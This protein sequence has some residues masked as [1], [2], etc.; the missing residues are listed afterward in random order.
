M[1]LT[2]DDIHA[3]QRRLAGQIVQ[4]PYSYSQTLSRI[5]GC[6]L[7]L[8][9]E[10]LQFTASFKERGA[11]N[12][13][14]SLSAEEKQRGVITVSAGNHAQ[15]VAYHA[16]KLGIRA[17][18]VMPVDTP[19]VKVENTKR[20]GAEVVQIGESFGEARVAM[21]K[22]AQRDQMVVVHP[23]DDPWVI[24]GQG[25]LGFEMMAQIPEID[26]LVVPI[27]GGGLISGI[28]L[29]VH[30]LSPSVE[31]VGV[32]AAHFPAMHDLYYQSKVPHGTV[33]TPNPERPHAPTIAD[34]IAVDQPGQLTAPIVLEHV[35]RIDLVSEAQLEQAIIYL[36]EI[37]KTV[38]EGA[39]AAGL[40]AVMARPDLFKGRRVGLV[41]CGGNIDSLTLSDIIQRS[42]VR[43][44][45]LARLSVSAR[46][47]PGSLARVATLVGQQGANIEEVTHQRAFADLP[48]RYAR[49][50]LVVSTRGDA[51][52]DSVVKA[53]AEAGFAA[54]VRD[55]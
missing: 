42:L 49:I 53:L 38:A 52:L 25:T 50:E 41:L 51:H 23:Y 15:G 29:A 32:Q 45:R 46:D 33:R 54:T 36:L 9:F 18:I 5:A 11:G 12:K 6:E 28:A 27:G 21:Q 35:S 26:T 47:V 7:Y 40:A 39:G 1:P 48:V 16:A 13:L 37:E 55:S 22:L 44:H 14:A 34:G 30:H 10:N 17:V 3:A 19:Y 43:S 31:I 20:L 4:T 24:A 2:I 8:K